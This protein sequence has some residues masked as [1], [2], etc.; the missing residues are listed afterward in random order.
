MKTTKKEARINTKYVHVT[1]HKLAN[2]EKDYWLELG[3]SFRQNVVAC[4]VGLEENHEAGCH[5]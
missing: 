5:S 1:L 4:L 3:M 2:K